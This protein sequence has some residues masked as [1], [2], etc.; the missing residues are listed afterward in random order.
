MKDQAYYDDVIAELIKQSRHNLRAFAFPGE[1]V[2]DEFL[3]PDRAKGVPAPP[4]EKPIP[5]DAETIELPAIDDSSLGQ[6]PLIDAFRIRRSQRIYSD[7]P[8]S[9]DELAFLCWAVAG[10]HK[11]GPDEVWTMRTAPSGGAR[12]PFETYI[13]VERVTGLEPGIYRYSG[14]TH[15]LVLVRT[16]TDGCKQLSQEAVQPFVGNSAACFIWTAVPY[17][18]EWKYMFTGAKQMAMDLGHYCQNLYLAAESIGAGTCAIAAYRQEI[19]DAFL[20]IDGDTEFTV[21]IAPVGKIPHE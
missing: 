1:A 20:G 21:Y 15:R 16:E 6:M 14:L 2:P 11:I 12:H 7:E 4:L 18:N 10:V 8:L 9:I 19:V 13:V 5:G 3:L 17:R